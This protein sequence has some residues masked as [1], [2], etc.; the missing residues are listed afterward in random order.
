MI[1][2]VAVV[3]LITFAYAQNDPSAI[4]YNRIATRS[5]VCRTLSEDFTSWSDFTGAVVPAGPTYDDGKGIKQSL[6]ILT[7]G[8]T[9]FNVIKS[10]IY[11]ATTDSHSAYATYRYA[12]KT[13]GALATPAYVDFY[14]LRQGLAIPS[15]GFASIA[16]FSPDASTINRYFTLDVGS[17]YVLRPNFVPDQTGSTQYIY[18]NGN[19]QLPSDQWVN[20]TVYMDW[21][22][23]NGI[24]AVWQDGVIQSVANLN[25]G[26]GFLNQAHFGL[27]A[28]GSI[29]TGNVYNYAMVSSQICGFTPA[30]SNF[31]TPTTATPIRN[32][33]SRALVSFLYFIVYAFFFVL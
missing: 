5:N 12:D 3:L 29:A 15:N 16:K 33:A 18:Q 10:S 2:C 11:A 25:G 17:D 32:N 1:T 7:S 4:P 31:Q 13:G 6:E 23:T 26:N 27:V 28:S 24:V 20:I 19:R 14:F 21:S 9:S 30:P 8:T 22:S